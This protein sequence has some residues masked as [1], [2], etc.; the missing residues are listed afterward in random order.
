ML[1]AIILRSDID[2][3][4]FDRRAPA[5]IAPPTPTRF[6]STAPDHGAS[7]RNASYSRGVIDIVDLPGLLMNSCE[8]YDAIKSIA[9]DGRQNSPVALIFPDLTRLGLVG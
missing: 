2:V 5:S 4:R 7:V 1:V 9:D 8:C 3:P 6:T